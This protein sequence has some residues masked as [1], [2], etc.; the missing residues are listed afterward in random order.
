MIGTQV[1]RLRGRFSTTPVLMEAHIWMGVIGF[2]MAFF[3]TAFVFSDRIAVTFLT[4]FLAVLTGT[5]GRYVVYIV[6]RISMDTS[7]SWMKSMT[8]LMK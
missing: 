7:F 3:H 6:P 8:V 5:I 4:M 1:Y 2:I